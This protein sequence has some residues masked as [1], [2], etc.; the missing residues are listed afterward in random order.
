MPLKRVEKTPMPERDAL[1]QHYITEV[2]RPGR[3]GWLRDRLAKI[4]RNHLMRLDRRAG[5]GK[6]RA[7]GELAELPEPVVVVLDDY[8]NVASPAVNEVVAE[9]LQDHV[10]LKK[11]LGEP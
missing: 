4:G 6:R 5:F 9:L 8:H 1:Q 10:Q 7:R 2:L 11:E 3:S